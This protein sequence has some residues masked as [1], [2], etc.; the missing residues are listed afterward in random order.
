MKFNKSYALMLASGL[1]AAASCQA[2][3]HLSGAI[4][5]SIQVMKAK[6]ESTTISQAPDQIFSTGFHLDADEDLGNGYGVETKLWLVAS[7]DNGQNAS[8]DGAYFNHTVMA[9]KTPYGKFGAGR[10]G[11]F[12][13]GF[14]PIGQWWKAD[15]FY[16]GA[17]DGG[18]QATMSGI[19][20]EL[21]KN[22]F[23]YESPDFS[24]LKFG[25]LY[26]LTGEA[27]EEAD[28][29][30]KDTKFW[31][32]FSSYRKGSVLLMA[33]VQ[34]KHYGD[35]SPYNHLGNLVRAKV[36]GRYD[37]GSMS[38]YG[39]YSYGRNEITYN[40]TAWGNRPDFTFDATNPDKDGMNGRALD[41]HSAY[42]GVK[43]AVGAWDLIALG[44]VQFGENKGQSSS[45]TTDPKFTR[46][47]G[48]VGAYYHLAKRTMIYSAATFSVVGKGWK[49]DKKTEALQRNMFILGMA[50]AF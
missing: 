8:P 24:G 39:G 12:G 44:Q 43:K 49:D 28:S 36:A 34:S 19:Y 15:P 4:D 35:A 38:Y 21:F 26:S 27:S 48:S 13:S 30:G 22:A 18:P 3:V 37:D 31:E 45:K 41:M 2:D 10:F 46:Y 23:Y 50:H 40:T 33:D 29:M 25:L 6:G 20:G 16:N 1:L 47:V 17:G 5:N 9:L 7:A 11:A 42:L 32:V 14:G